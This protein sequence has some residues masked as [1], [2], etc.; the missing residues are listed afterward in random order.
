MWE[1][2]NVGSENVRKSHSRNIE[3]I[4]LICQFFIFVVIG[5]LAC[6][7][8]YGQEQLW[9]S[10]NLNGEG[11]REMFAEDAP[12]P[13]AREAVDVFSTHENFLGGRDT[14]ETLI[15][16]FIS[17]TGI[18]LALEVGGLRSHNLNGLPPDQVGE[19]T[20]IDELRKIQNIYGA[21]GVVSILQMDSPIGYTLASGGDSICAF[22]PPEAARE[23][24]DY[25]ER[26]LGRYPRMRFALIEPVPW[27]HVGDFPAYPGQDRGDLKEILEIFLDTLEAR[28]LTL[29][30][31][32]ADCPYSYTNYQRVEGYQGWAKLR[33]LEEWVEGRGLRFGLIYNDEQSGQ[34]GRGSSDSL[35]H[36]RTLDYYSTYADSGGSPGNMLIMSWYPRPTLT[37][38]EDEHY[39]FMNIVKDFAGL[40]DRFSVR[41]G[42]PWVVSE[43]NFEAFPNPF[44]SRTN[45][46]FSMSQ[47]GEATVN[48]F[49]ISGRV[50]WT[51]S[52]GF[53]E[54]GSHNAHV[55]AGDLASGLYYFGINGGKD[56]RAIVLVR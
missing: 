2:G 16:P 30:A 3:A 6:R 51:T 49:D 8:V 27:Y 18:Q 38:P 28:G 39:T 52:L 29:E 46:S 25:M 35:Y 31:F 14:L 54:T 42:E 10:P 40:M 45:I 17:R 47:P 48:L 44:N 24:A 12:W 5:V 56:R 1:G 41:E 15:V 33:E 36:R 4:S 53:L 13:V 21:G 23:T 19:A 50:V 22:E 11:Y 32:H 43:P 7:Q 20:A 34:G 37:I 9:I 26:I 55:D